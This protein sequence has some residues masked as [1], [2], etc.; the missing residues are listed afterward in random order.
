[1]AA[2]AGV[3]GGSMLLPIFIVLMGFSES[4]AIPLVSCTV[5]GGACAS[6]W[7]NG[8]K[9]QKGLM[10]IDI[11]LLM[12]PLTIM[13]ALL[14]N[15]LGRNINVEALKGL[16]VL[17]LLTLGT[18]LL[19]NMHTEPT[20]SEEQ[21]PLITVPLSLNV[22]NAECKKRSVD[23]FFY[24][25]RLLAMLTSGCLIVE[26]VIPKR[27]CV[28]Q[29]KSILQCCWCVIFSFCVLPKSGIA[30]DFDST[31]THVSKRAFLFSS[32]MAGVMAGLFGIGGG[33]VKGPLLIELGLSAASTAATASLM[34]MFT[35]LVCVVSSYYYNQL[36][37]GFGLLCCIV[38]FLST[39]LSLTV[40]SSRFPS[41][42]KYSIAVTILLSAFF[43]GF[44]SLFEYFNPPIVVDVPFT[45]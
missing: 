27:F 44:H 13:G 16:L 28:W 36:N 5:L 25:L 32:M 9:D 19:H 37:A 26:F 35:T 31:S 33:V 21:M 29:L 14:G 3:G 43:V 6:C 42:V 20:T 24:K 22:C 2:S 41:A 30:V 15:S 40:T 12:E 39:L 23:N 7:N 10:N 11:A 18:R 38:G 17:L 4:T 1:M 34:I 45:C 8:R